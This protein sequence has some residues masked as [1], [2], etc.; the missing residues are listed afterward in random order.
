MFCY[1]AGMPQ[2][3]PTDAVTR[4][5]IRLIKAQR[6][7]LRL[8]EADIKAAGFPPLAWYDVLWELKRAGGTIRPQEMETRLLLAQ[9]NVSR[10]IDRLVE[11]GLVERQPYAGDGRGQVIAITT[12]GRDLQ[13]RMWPVYGAAIQKYVGAPLGNDRE[14]EALW[15]LL[16]PLAGDE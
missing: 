2:P 4:A 10:L 8:V 12:A 14:A 13:K 15:R 6:R 11:A 7:A 9:H 3:L 5:W 16:E 1:G